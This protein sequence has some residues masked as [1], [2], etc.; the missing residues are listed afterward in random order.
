[1]Y[2][3]I[4]PHGE[5]IYERSTVITYLCG[6]DGSLD[7]V[8]KLADGRVDI[9]WVDDLLLIGKLNGL[10][11][12]LALS[13]LVNICDPHHGDLSVVSSVVLC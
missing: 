3:Q 2:I 11:V 6:Y 10:N 5:Y 4:I 13:W 1:M 7:H 12:A 8:S 9:L